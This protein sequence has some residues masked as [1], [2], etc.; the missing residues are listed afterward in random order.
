MKRSQRREDDSEVEEAG[1]KMEDLVR[2]IESN[3]IRTAAKVSGD[4]GEK[5]KT[6][7][8][9]VERSKAM[10]GDKRGSWGWGTTFRH[11]ILGTGKENGMDIA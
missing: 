6:R 7:A 8:E 2:R 9:G 1:G 11:I 5:E 10:V 3:K 4:G